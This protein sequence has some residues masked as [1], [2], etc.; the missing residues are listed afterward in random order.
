MTLSTD[1]QVTVLLELQDDAVEQLAEIKREEMQWLQAFLLFY[2]AVVAWCVARWLPSPRSEAPLAASEESVVVATLA[3]SFLATGLFTFHFIRTRWSYYG[4]AARLANIQHLLGLYDGAGWHGGAPLRG[5]P[6][7]GFIGGLES[8][9]HTTRPMSSFLTRIVYL[10]GANM[11][12]SLVCWSS[13]SRSS[14]HAGPWFLVT[15]FLLNAVIAGGAFA[16]DY[17]HFLRERPSLEEPGHAATRGIA[18]ESR[19]LA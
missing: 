10:V 14:G 1:Q 8:W 13:L 15:C 12:V 2:G 11:V 18:A 19:P 6:Y 7:R 3:V 4:V 17:V 9:Q 5:N 16:L